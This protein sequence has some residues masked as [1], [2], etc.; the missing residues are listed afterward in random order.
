MGG[1]RVPSASNTVAAKKGQ[2]QALTEFALSSP[3]I[4]A[5][6]SADQFAVLSDV[7][8]SIFLAQLVGSDG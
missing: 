2:P 1:G 5:E 6:M 7:V 4:E 8:G 3:E